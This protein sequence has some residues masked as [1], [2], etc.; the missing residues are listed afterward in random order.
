[1]WKIEEGKKSSGS[2]KELPLYKKREY[3]DLLKSKKL[4]SP[5]YN[6][7]LIL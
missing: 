1:M 2:P 6:P 3:L 4:L 7:Q 5:Y